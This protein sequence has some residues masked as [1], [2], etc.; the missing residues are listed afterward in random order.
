[1]M[2][3]VTA[4]PTIKLD[5]RV[6]FLYHMTHIR[7]LGSILEHGLMSHNAAHTKGL[8]AH[9]ISEPTVNGRRAYRFPDAAH[10]V[11]DY[12]PLYFNPLNPMQY[13]RKGLGDDLVL[14][15]YSP[16]I[17]AHDGVYVS[18]GN[19]ASSMTT[20]Y[21]GKD[22]DMLNFNAIFTRFWNDITDGKRIVCSE[23]LYPSPL[24]SSHLQ[25]IFVRGNSSYI[26]THVQLPAEYR[27]LLVT[28]SKVFFS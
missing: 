16:S 1:M 6:T 19:A 8:V 3:A 21:H 27:N 25:R 14:L 23:V 2:T 22:V 26:K 4:A 10:S 13:C 9:D 12:A 17:L 28:N 20:F 15:A 11:H 18:D 7:N 24:N 5:G